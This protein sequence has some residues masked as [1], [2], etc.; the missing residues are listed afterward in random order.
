LMSTSGIVRIKKPLHKSGRRK[1]EK[2]LTF[3]T[4]GDIRRDRKN[5]YPSFINRERIPHVVI[6]PS[7][8]LLR[9][10]QNSNTTTSLISYC[11]LW[12]KQNQIK[13]R[14][15]VITCYAKKS[16]GL[17]G[18]KIFSD[19]HGYQAAQNQR[20]YQ[21]CKRVNCLIHKP[22][23]RQSLRT[24]RLSSGVIGREH[25]VAYLLRNFSEELASGLSIA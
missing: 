9:R 21:L 22:G 19:A 16:Y 23:D 6:K 3:L 1:A 24:T 10:S 5:K 8:H 15:P 12:G 7:H 14:L 4:Q 17:R 11:I 25:F 18:V 20:F 13:N 2:V